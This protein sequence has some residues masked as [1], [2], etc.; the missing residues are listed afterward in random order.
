MITANAGCGKTFSLAN[1]VI[2]WMIERWRE[3]GDIGADGIVAATFTRKAAGEI[4]HRILAHLAESVL[5]QDKLDEFQASMGLASPATQL[6]CSAVLDMLIGSLHVMQVDT[7]DALFGRIGR[8]C[9]GLL[10]LPA[11]W[12]ICSDDAAARLRRLAIDDL[13]EACS[14]DDLQAIVHAAEEGVLKGKAHDGIT[15]ALWETKLLKLWI[16]TMGTPVR[17]AWEWL[18]MQPA[19]AIAPGA[20][21]LSDAEHA[22]AVEAFRTAELPLN[23]SG[24]PNGSWVN[25]RAGKLAKIEAGE[26]LTMLDGAFSMRLWDGQIFSKAVGTEEIL[27]AGRAMV[28]HDKA[29]LVEQ[30]QAQMR[31][32]LM[33][34]GTAATTLLARKQESG[35]FQFSDIASRLAASAFFGSMTASDLQYKLDMSI[36]DLALDEFQDT[37][38]T[39]FNVL[40]P[41]VDEILAGKGAHDGDRKLLVVGDIKQSIYGWRGGT[42]GLLQELAEVGGDNIEQIAL[43]KSWRSAKPIMDFVNRVFDGIAGNGALGSLDRTPVDSSAFTDAGLPDATT[44]SGPVGEALSRWPWSTHFTAKEDMPG[45]VV[46]HGLTALEEEQT[47]LD[48]AVQATVDI[49]Q[50]RIAHCESIGVLV[51]KNDHGA[52][53]AAALREAGIDAS[54][55][56]AAAISSMPA[57]RLVLRVLHL[58]VHPGDRKAGFVVSHSALAPW[59]GLSPLESIPTDRQAPALQGAA[60]TVRRKVLDQGLANVMQEM[61]DHLHDQCDAPNARALGHV[62]RLAQS[63]DDNGIRSLT[64][65]ADHV[66]QTKLGSSSGGQVRVM[67]V[68]GAKGLEFDE[69]VLPVMEDTLVSSKKSLLVL[70]D[71]PAGKLLGV[72]PSVNKELRWAVPVLEGIAQQSLASQIADRLSTLYVALTRARRATHVLLAVDRGSK[73]E[74]KPADRRCTPSTILRS[75]IDEIDQA[76]ERIPLDAQGP[77]ECWVMEQGDWREAQRKVPPAPPPVHRPLPMEAPPPLA[78]EP[79]VTVEVR[80]GKPRRE[81]IALHECLADVEWADSAQSVDFSAAFDRAARQMGRPIGATQRAALSRRVQDAMNGPMG[82]AMRPEAFAAWETDTLEVLMELT[83]VADGREHRLDRLVLGHKDGEV[84]RACVQDFKSGIRDAELA[85]ATYQ[86]QL[87]RYVDIVAATWELSEA[88]VDAQ[89]LLIDA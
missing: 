58:A 84:V 49:V 67:T 3:T 32:W 52:A 23:K 39:Q 20:R 76:L 41:V 1:R 29:V 24:Q 78:E 2:G 81:G 53:I 44:G 26:P 38:A 82:D 36:R 13:L 28:A 70:T 10:D 57:I 4:L 14:Q 73:G 27:A 86:D 68:F 74:W 11:G 31:G 51:F 56:G 88:A 19:D 71:G 37:S 89:L 59:L 65:F 43:Q 66:R 55:E 21:R 7:L 62:V 50:E 61:S 48:R 40:R 75:A 54:Q 16:S 60:A 46:V 87:D 17:A 80:A 15:D 42:P 35:L 63:W 12:Q 33:L 47:A 64:A 25:A 77:V 69:V 85:Q 5:D 45:A 72:S 22:Q 6:E 18:L 9:P 8:A 79:P 83:L 34:V 30:A